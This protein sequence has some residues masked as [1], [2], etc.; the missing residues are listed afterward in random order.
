MGLDL[1]LLPVESEEVAF[2]H[3][4]LNCERRRDLFE[5]LLELKTT[6]VPERFG[7]YLCRDEKYEEPHY[8]NTQ[9]TPYREPLTCVY[10]EQLIAF[11]GH[12]DV[13]DN[14]RNQAIWAYLAHL[15]A[16]TRIALYWH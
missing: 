12:V 13:H 7:T 4:V 2:S 1:A 16:K 3:S 6:A 8:G 9:T 11:G 10:V 15:P 14:H 5:E